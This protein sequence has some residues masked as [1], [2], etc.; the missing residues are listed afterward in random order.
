M[1]GPHFLHLSKGR[2]ID[3][4]EDKPLQ[5]SEQLLVAYPLNPNYCLTDIFFAPQGPARALWAKD[6]HQQLWV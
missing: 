1:S 3:G 2:H 6:L 5:F 4:R